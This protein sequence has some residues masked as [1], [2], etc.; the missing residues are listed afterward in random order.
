MNWDRL[1]ELIDRFSRHR[2]LVV[3]DFYLDAYWMVDQTKST[4]SLE[5]SWHN[6]PV[7]DQQ[8]SPGA[9]GTVTNNLKALG[10]GEVYTIGIIGEDGFGTT[11]IQELESRGCRTDFMIQ[12][13]ERVTPTYL[14]PIYCGYEGVRMEASRFDIENQRPTP[15]L[16]QNLLLTNLRRCLPMVNAVI[17][18]D[19]T[20]TDNLGGVTDLVRDHICHLALQFPEK[21]FFADSRTRI[22]K[23]QNLL[24]K[25]NRFEAIRAVQPEW[26]GT[27]LTV[28]EAKKIGTELQRQT[29]APLFITCGENGILSFDGSDVQHTVGIVVDGPVDPVGAGD[30]VTAGLVSTLISGGSMSEAAFVG[31]LAASITVTKIGTTGTAS[32]EEVIRQ[33]SG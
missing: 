31:N 17:I 29:N 21:I 5:T 14:K 19:Q 13:S 6:S 20:P 15:L 12:T 16:L 24:V 27:D 10:I 33:L 26:S 4:L 32:S 25:P 2:V 23:Y 18:A 3:G 28:K 1:Q 9:A 7:V 11:L 30:S 22:G 8:Y